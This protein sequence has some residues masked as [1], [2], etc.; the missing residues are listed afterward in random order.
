MTDPAPGG[1]QRIVNVSL[2][3][4]TVVRRSPE[5]EHERAV[6]IFDLIEE[7]QFALIDDDEGPYSLHLS[8]EENRLVID[9]RTAEETPILLFSSGDTFARKSTKM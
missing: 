4:R 8:I 9:V 7:N 3:E 5:V 1:S 6:A 2:D